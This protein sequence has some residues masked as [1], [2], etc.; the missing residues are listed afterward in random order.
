MSFYSPK[1][2][3]TSAKNSKKLTENSEGFL[4]L[5]PY[6]QAIFL[7]IIL[8]TYST[9]LMAKLGLIY[10]NRMSYLRPTNEKLVARSI[11]QIE[12]RLQAKRCSIPRAIILKNFLAQLNNHELSQNST[13]HFSLI[14]ATLSALLPP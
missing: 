12:E 11:L 5:S 2:L 13:H 9:G 4:R 7:K 14:E 10:K 8:N 1:A 6:F 3:K